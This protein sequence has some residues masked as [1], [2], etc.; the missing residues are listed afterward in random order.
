METKDKKKYTH[1]I[2]RRHEFVVLKSHGGYILINTKKC[3]SN[4][5]THL[6]SLNSCISIVKLIERKEMPKN[7][8]RYFLTS[9]LRV[10]RDKEYELKIKDLMLDYSS[11]MQESTYIDYTKCI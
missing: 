10:N 7:Q 8:S 5:H 1:A 2:F 4:G 6:S 11:L 3:F 9:I